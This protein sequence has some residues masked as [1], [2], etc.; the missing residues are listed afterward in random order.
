[1][2]KTMMFSIIFVSGLLFFSA[3]EDKKS[4]DDHVINV[5]LELFQNSTK[6]EHLAVNVEAALVFKVTESDGHTDDHGEVVTGMT[7]HATIGHDGSEM[8]CEEHEPGHYEL[9]YTF[10][11]TGTYEVHFEFHHDGTDMEEHFD[12]VVE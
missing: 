8:E 4:E 11:E 5:D 3:C 2:K 10:T 9:H 7:A 12:V 1:M 6:V